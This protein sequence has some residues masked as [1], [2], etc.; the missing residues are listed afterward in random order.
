MSEARSP[1]RKEPEKF[2]VHE[3]KSLGRHKI[4]IQKVGME[5]PSRRAGKPLTVLKDFSLYVE[6]REF[7]CLLGP[8]GCGKTT[9]LNSIAGF[10][11]LTSG[12]IQA[13]NQ[14][15]EGPGPDRG[16]TR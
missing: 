16:I 9:L 7:V 8:S 13:N 15:V 4:E 10:I 2:P 12:Q 14:L 11:E 3:D 1:T 5:F 6:D